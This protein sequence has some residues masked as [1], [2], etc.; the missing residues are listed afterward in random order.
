MH[1]DIPF[2]TAMTAAVEAELEALAQWLGLTGSATPDED[3]AGEPA[4]PAGQGYSL[5]RSS[6]QGSA[7]LL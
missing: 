2:T 6:F 5:K 1:Q 7:S 4:D 3:G